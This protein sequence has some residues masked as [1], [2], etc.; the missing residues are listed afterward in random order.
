M[1]T[2]YQENGKNLIL[3]LIKILK[4]TERPKFFVIFYLKSSIEQLSFDSDRLCLIQYFMWLRLEPFM[5]QILLYKKYYLEITL[6]FAFSLRE[7][8]LCGRLSSE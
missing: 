1:E 8:S 7:V 3:Y 5:S 6:L 4:N 2:K